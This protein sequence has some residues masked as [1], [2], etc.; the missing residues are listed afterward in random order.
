MRCMFFAWGIS[1]AAIAMTQKCV[2]LLLGGPLVLPID[3]VFPIGSLEL[4]YA[5]SNQYQYLGAVSLD[6]SA[7]DYALCC[8]KGTP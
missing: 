4:Y 5:Y 1:S 2:S 3:L 6:K 7:K 8:M